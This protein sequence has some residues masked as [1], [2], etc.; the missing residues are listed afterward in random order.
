MNTFKRKISMNNIFDNNEA[1]ITQLKR[2]KH[3][4][5]ES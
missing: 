4:L 3:A 2:D 5:L 1:A